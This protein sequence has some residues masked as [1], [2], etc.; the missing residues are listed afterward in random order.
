VK[1]FYY[2]Q[3]QNDCAYAIVKMCTKYFFNKDIDTK[4]LENF[5][6]TSKGLNIYNLEKLLINQ[7]IVAKSYRCDLSELLKI[8]EGEIFILPTVAENVGHYVLVKPENHGFRIF[9]PST[10]ISFKDNLKDLFHG[11]V[12]K[13][14]PEQANLKNKHYK[15]IETLVPYFTKITINIIGLLIIFSSSRLIENGISNLQLEQSII[16][17]LK[18]SVTYI[19]MMIIL[20]FSDLTSEFILG[21][22]FKNKLEKKLKMFVASI[23]FTKDYSTKFEEQ[24][25]NVDIYLSNYLSHNIIVKPN[26]YASLFTLFLTG[27]FL[28]Q[29]QLV[30]F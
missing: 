11:I 14:F 13:I 16:D 23:K 28:L 25:R 7:N 5:K 18:I 17:I 29:I 3:T 2:Q 20:E 8:K 9:D 4:A 22:I 19:L 30:Y 21:L 1:F 27:I 26:F 24:R 15:L 12:I 6:L 10:G